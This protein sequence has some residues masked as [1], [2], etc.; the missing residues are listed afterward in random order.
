MANKS[1]KLKFRITIRYLK[2]INQIDL[3][4]NI[5]ENRRITCFDEIKVI[6]IVSI[7]SIVKVVKMICVPNDIY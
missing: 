5:G 6:K 1:I 3:E 4:D 7:V 2:F